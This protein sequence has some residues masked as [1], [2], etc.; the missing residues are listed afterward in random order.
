MEICASLTGPVMGADAGDLARATCT[1]CGA[2]DGAGEMDASS[3]PG[4]GE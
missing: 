3:Y 2:A 1:V 4:C